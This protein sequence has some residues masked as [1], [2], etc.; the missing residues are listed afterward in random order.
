MQQTTVTSTP[1]HLLCL[2]PSEGEQE[3]SGVGLQRG[4]LTEP[5]AAGPHGVHHL[6]ATFPQIPHADPHVATLTGPPQT[7]NTAVGGCRLQTDESNPGTERELPSSPD[8]GVCGLQG[9]DPDDRASSVTL[10]DPLSPPGVQVP[11]MDG[12]LP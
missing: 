7:Q 12:T 3:V 5:D 4:A 2:L 6:A 8:E 10:H 11:D 9:A 1:T